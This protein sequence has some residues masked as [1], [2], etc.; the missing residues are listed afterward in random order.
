[1]VDLMCFCSVVVEV[2]CGV[3]KVMLLL[4]SSVFMFVKLVFFRLCLSL[5]MW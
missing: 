1:M 2:I 3:E 5:G 4:F